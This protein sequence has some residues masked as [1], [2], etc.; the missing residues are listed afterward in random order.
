MAND[1]YINVTKLSLFT[2]YPLIFMRKVITIII[3]GYH[4]NAK[5]ANKLKF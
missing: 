2:F 1:F 4:S 3:S 5:S